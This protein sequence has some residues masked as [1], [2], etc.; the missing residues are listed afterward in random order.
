MTKTSAQTEGTSPVNYLDHTA[1]VTILDYTGHGTTLLDY[2]DQGEILG[3]IGRGP[4]ATEVRFT[5]LEA[6]PPSGIASAVETEEE[7]PPLTTASGKTVRQTRK[8]YGA[9]VGLPDRRPGVILVVSRITA[10]AARAEGRSVTD[11]R[12]PNEMVTHRGRIVGCLSL[13]PA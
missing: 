6:I 12:T 13:T 11:L 8:T 2:D 10:N 7:L 1:P 5:V 3:T 4:A 9:T